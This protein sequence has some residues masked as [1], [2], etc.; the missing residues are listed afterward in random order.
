MCYN[1]KTKNILY[2]IC[3]VYLKYININKI[4]FSYFLFIFIIINL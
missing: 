2:K 4:Y 3:I 1:N